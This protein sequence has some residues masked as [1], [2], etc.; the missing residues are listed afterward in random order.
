MDVQTDLPKIKE[1]LDK[2]REV[3]IV[4]HEKPT[5]D[6]I[7]STL[8]LYL[9]LVSLGKKV[10]VA[11]PEP[12][13]V[14]LSNFIGVQKIVSEL[15]NKNFVISLDYVDGSIEK[16][17]YNIEGDKFNLVIEPRAGF[18]PFTSEKVHYS[19]AGVNA[20]LIFAVDTIHLGG[21]KKLYDGDKN[22][23]ASKPVINIDRHANNAMFGAI[24]LVDPQASSTAE[25]VAQFLSGLGVKLTVDIAS[26]I[27]NALYSATDGFAAQNVTPLAFELA[28]TCL[29]G[30]GR[31]F[32][33]PAGGQPVMPATPTPAPAVPLVPAQPK[34]PAPNVQTPADW[35]KPKIFKSSTNIS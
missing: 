18:D 7:G 35:L 12:I 14:E 4:T 32:G 23:F 8:A 20:D 16:V 24:N 1:Q 19:Y 26:N 10:T 11:C 21:L 29:R 25:V 33:P 2:A 17:S 28:A 3:L 34:Q 9:G 31:R 15:G 5:S 22:L 13:T 27:L 30:G 6:S